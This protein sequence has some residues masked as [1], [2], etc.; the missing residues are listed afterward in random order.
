VIFYL[1]ENIEIDEITKRNRIN[2]YFNPPVINYKQFLLMA[3]AFF[4]IGFSIFM[5]SVTLM[6]ILLIL[7]FILLSIGGLCLYYFFDRKK[8]YEGKLVTDSEIDTY[9]EDDLNKI[10]QYILQRLNL[11]PSQLMIDTMYTSY[12]LPTDKKDL[13]QE[14][15]K[16]GKDGI[17][18]FTPILIN[19]VNFTTEELIVFNI[20][21]DFIKGNVIQENT[22]SYYYKDIVSISTNATIDTLFLNKKLINES[23]TLHTS[24]GTSETIILKDISKVYNYK[25]YIP[26]SEPDSVIIA[27]RKMLREKK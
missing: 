17:Q 9:L 12:Y 21:F 6:L 23:F 24:A 1:T 11:D 2:L 16:I 26:Y 15:V 22:I 20:H 3:I 25:N 8:K 14:H 27:L 4:A 10:K 19:A 18:R 5:I 7:A 13:I